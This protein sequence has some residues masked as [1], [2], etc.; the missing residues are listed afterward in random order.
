MLEGRCSVES[1]S[2]A[3]PCDWGDMC[4]HKPEDLALAKAL[5]ETFSAPGKSTPEDMLPSFLD[6]AQQLRE[7]GIGDPPYEIVEWKA[8]GRY[9]AIFTVNGLLVGV[10]HGEGEVL[11]EVIARPLTPHVSEDVRQAREAIY[12][13]TDRRRD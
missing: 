13:G 7:D 5:A 3:C 12:G 4:S 6:D 2:A 1:E 9:N 8:E 11:A 10:E